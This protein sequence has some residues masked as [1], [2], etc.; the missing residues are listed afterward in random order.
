[1]ELAFHKKSLRKLCESESFAKRKLGSDIATQLK[2]RIADFRAI[3]YADDLTSMLP[4]ISEINVSGELYFVANLHGD[5]IISF[6]ANHPN[7]PINN[8]K[9]DWK[10]VRRIK[11]MRIGVNNYEQ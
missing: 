1:M 8:N 3:K 7:N 6:C 11:I 4:N 9:I 2:N 5:H 10:K